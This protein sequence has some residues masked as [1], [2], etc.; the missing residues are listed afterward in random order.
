MINLFINRDDHADLRDM[1]MEIGLTWQRKD[2]ASR[3]KRAAFGCEVLKVT[4]PHYRLIKRGFL[5]GEI[6]QL[7][8]LEGKLLRGTDL[9]INESD[10]IMAI[11]GGLYD[12]WLEA[13]RGQAK[14]VLEKTEPL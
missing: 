5:N 9:T 1:A 3:I 2:D 13:I 4:W 12:E 6:R 11:R 7:N 8:E 10:F 14:R